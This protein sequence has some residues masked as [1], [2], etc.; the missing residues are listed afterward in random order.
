MQKVTSSRDLFKKKVGFG[1]IRQGDISRWAK[2]TVNFLY[3]E[4]KNRKVPTRALEKLPDSGIAEKPAL[5]VRQTSAVMIGLIDG[6]SKSQEGADG[7]E[8]VGISCMIAGRLAN[9]GRT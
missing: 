2:G 8:T 1:A 7:I 6:P 3:P 5:P 4:P 9:Q